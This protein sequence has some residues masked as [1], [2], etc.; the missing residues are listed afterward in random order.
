[1]M[2]K[3]NNAAIQRRWVSRGMLCV[4]WTYN[5]DRRGNTHDSY[6]DE[7]FRRRYPM[8]DEYRMRKDAMSQSSLLSVAHTVAR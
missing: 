4:G 1:M 5:Y 6:T 8:T 3:S 7:Q 2:M